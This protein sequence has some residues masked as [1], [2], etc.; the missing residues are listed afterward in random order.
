MVTYEAESFCLEQSRRK[1]LKVGVVAPRFVRA[2][3]CGDKAPRISNGSNMEPNIMSLSN[4]NGGYEERAQ[5][6]LTT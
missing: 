6:R 5:D 3:Q 4:V 1:Q 2:R